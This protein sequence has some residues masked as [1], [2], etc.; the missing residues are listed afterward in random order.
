VAKCI[1]PVALITRPIAGAF[2]GLSAR[3][4]ASCSS[5]SLYA[6]KAESDEAQF[7]KL[8]STLDPHGA[9]SAYVKGARAAVQAREQSCNEPSVFASVLTASAG[10]LVI[11]ASLELNAAPDNDRPQCPL[12]HR[13]VA[14]SDI[15]QAWGTLSV[16]HIVIEAIGSYHISRFTRRMLSLLQIAW[17]FCCRL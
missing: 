15:A 5:A 16:A 13:E 3:A 6:S 17:A 12:E 2:L 7:E 8:I 10:L 11:H 14:K 1:H 4:A 9:I